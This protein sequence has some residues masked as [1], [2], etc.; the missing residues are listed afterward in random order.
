MDTLCM[1]GSE[2][3][4]DKLGLQNSF[5]TRSGD[6]TSRSIHKMTIGY[7][8]FYEFFNSDRFSAMGIPGIAIMTIEA[9]HET[10]L[11][12]HDKANT[13]AIYGSARFK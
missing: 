2:P 8:F 6:A 10:T 11:K 9:A 7:G 1:A 5:T 3:I 4:A 13:G 12:K